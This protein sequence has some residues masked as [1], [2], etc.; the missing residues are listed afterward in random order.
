MKF[1]KTGNEDPKKK[2]DNPEGENDALKSAALKGKGLL[3]KMDEALKVKAKGG[4]YEYCCGVKTW[5][6]D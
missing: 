2:A 5:V 1:K 4:H 6:K 3:Q